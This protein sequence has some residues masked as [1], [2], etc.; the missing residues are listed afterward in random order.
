MKLPNRGF[1]IYADGK[2]YVKQAYLCALSLKVNNNKY[3]VSLI[4]PNPVPKN[5][6]Q[7]FDQVIDVPWYKETDSRFHTENRWKIYHATPY[8]E[9]V[10]LDSDVLVLQD[11]EHFWD[12]MQ[13][14]YLYFPT[15]VFTYR[16]EVV[17]DSYYRK[18]FVANGLPNVYNT[19]HFFKKT[20]KCKLFYEWVEYISNNWEL[21]YGNFCKEYYPK[22]PSMD[23]TC[24]IAAKILDIDTEITN[25]KFDVPMLVHMKPKI[26]KWLNGANSWQEKLG[27]YI[28]PEGTVKVGNFT[29][30]SVFHYTEDNFATD[31]KIEKFEK[32][33]GL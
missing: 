15:K 19:L 23:I 12:L 20:D 16:N 8:E 33:L 21:F 27:T 14:Y 11:L 32:L 7:V 18:A 13:N 17:T 10:V 25:N 3:P 28:A 30:N 24:A 5:R 9:T 26:Q 1:V 29:Q 22:Q 31:D 4:T 2:E 6:A